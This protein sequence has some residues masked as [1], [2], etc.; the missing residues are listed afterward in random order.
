MGLRRLVT[1]F[2]L[3]LAALAVTASPSSAIVGGSDAAPGEYPSVAEITFGAFGCTGTLISP[4]T[5]L[6]PGTAAR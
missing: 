6:P 1:S 5:V 3:A 4:D 2:A